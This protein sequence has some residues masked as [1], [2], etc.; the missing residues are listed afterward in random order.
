MKSL[1]VSSPLLWLISIITLTILKFFSDSMICVTDTLFTPDNWQ[2][3][4]KRNSKSSVWNLP[5]KTQWQPSSQSKYSAI[6]LA[7]RTVLFLCK[8]S[9]FRQASWMGV[10]L[11]PLPG[12]QPVIKTD[13]QF[14]LSSCKLC[15]GSDKASLSCCPFCVCFTF[16]IFQSWTVVK[17][18]PEYHLCPS[19]NDCQ[20]LWVC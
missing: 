10:E 8:Q 6:S 17:I 16:R 12:T 7:T 14:N 11:K 2:Y 3:W 1:T 19:W 13:N 18:N 15:I 5:R 4:L 20:I 9:F